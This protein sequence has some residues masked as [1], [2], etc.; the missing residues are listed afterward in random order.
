MGDLSSGKFL[1]PAHFVWWKK[2]KNHEEIKEKYLKLIDEDF[3]LNGDF[4][5]ENKTWSCDVTSSYFDSNM[6]SPILDKYFMD[7]VVWNS[8][9]EMLLDLSVSYNLPVPKYSNIA[10]LWYNKYQPG[11]WQEMHDHAICSLIEE[12]D[13]KVKKIL[14]PAF[15]GI[16]LLDLNEDNKTVF[17]STNLVTCFSPDNSNSFTTQGI[18]EG[19]VILFPSELPH[20]VNRCVNSRT[21][22]SFNIASNY[23]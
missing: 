2:L 10:S 1:F 23:E 8:V 14:R 7:N 4:Y 16:Y 22:V 3:K 20:Y 15:S 5:R 21:T 11:D 18:E 6:I 19:C 9:D 12:T 13:K 17:Y